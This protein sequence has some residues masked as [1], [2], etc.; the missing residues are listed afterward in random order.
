[1]RCVSLPPDGY[2]RNRGSSIISCA[3]PLNDYLSEINFQQDCILCYL[4]FFLTIRRVSRKEPE[5]GFGV[6][7]C[8]YC[9][10]RRKGG[11]C[12]IT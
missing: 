6:V 9:I 4:H 11:M 2:G 1:M 5:E 8:P 7:T 10:S 12:Y 3:F